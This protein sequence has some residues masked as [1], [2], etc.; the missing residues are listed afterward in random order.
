MP[1]SGR[2]S[3]AV[4]R[5]RSAAIC[6]PLNLWVVSPDQVPP[7]GPNDFIAAVG[8][9]IQRGGSIKQLIRAVMMDAA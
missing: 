6:S 9:D 3:P 1:A 5:R 4:R 7:P 2:R 8:D